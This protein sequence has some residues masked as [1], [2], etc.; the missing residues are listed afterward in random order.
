[1]ICKHWIWYRNQRVLVYNR[2]TIQCL[3]QINLLFFKVFK[4]YSLYPFYLYI[5][6]GG[7]SKN[8]AVTIFF[9]SEGHPG[10]Y[11]VTLQKLK[12]G[13]NTHHLKQGIDIE[14]A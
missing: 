4:Y 6:C 9:F 10:R 1:M 8:N 5:V 11:C 2:E 7:F 14:S 12:N 3:Q 13:M